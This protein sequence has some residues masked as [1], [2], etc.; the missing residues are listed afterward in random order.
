MVK[1]I[2]IWRLKPE[3]H[4]NTAAQ[5]ALLIKQKMEA[6]QGKIPGLLKIEIGLDFVRS[7]TSGD[8]A[9]YCEFTDRAALDVYRDHPEHK[10]VFPFIAAARTERMMADYELP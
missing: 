1:H 4:G 8:L 9:L 7:E 5:N 6:L 10:A 3:A 2:I